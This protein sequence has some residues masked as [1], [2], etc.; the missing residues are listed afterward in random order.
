MEKA[1][2]ATGVKYSGLTEEEWQRGYNFL[3]NNRATIGFVW[4]ETDHTYLIV[5]EADDQA[6]RDFER[7]LRG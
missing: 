1:P 6:V 7:A 5:E 4:E 2:S 3:R